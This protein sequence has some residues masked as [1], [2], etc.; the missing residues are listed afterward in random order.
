MKEDAAERATTY[1]E[2]TVR[3]LRDLKPRTLPVQVSKEIVNK[4]IETATSYTN[5]AKHYAG[6]NQPVTSLACVAY[7]EGLLDALKFLD[8]VELQSLLL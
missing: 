6:K 5:D 3:A 1:I 4:I 8:L 2:A 7:A